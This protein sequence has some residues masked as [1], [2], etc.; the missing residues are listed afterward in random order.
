V[1][2]ALLAPSGLNAFS[3]EG[4][5]PTVYQ[6]NIGLQTK[7]PYDFRL[8]MSYVGSLSR[9][10]SDLTSTPFRTEHSIVEKTRIRLDLAG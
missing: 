7:L 9:C 1:Q 10:C 5:I 8:D 4:D 2:T 3:E 6:F